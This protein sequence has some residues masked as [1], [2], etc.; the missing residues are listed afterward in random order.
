MK[1]KV[2][3]TLLKS[4]NAAPNQSYSDYWW[5][6]LRKISLA[7]GDSLGLEAQRMVESGF[8]LAAIYACFVGLLEGNNSGRI[9]KC[10]GILESWMSD[11][12][13]FAQHAEISETLSEPLVESIQLLRC[14]K[15][16]K[17][18][19]SCM[20]IIKLALKDFLGKGDG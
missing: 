5:K 4:L 9:T 10:L 20:K 12:L 7:L 18:A 16:R 19:L 1:Y 2:E 8:W 3:A 6:V 14:S 11:L 17:T 13:M 15:T